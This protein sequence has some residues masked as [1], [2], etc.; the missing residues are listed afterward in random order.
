M[1]TTLKSAAVALA[2]A[3]VTLVLAGAGKPLPT[4]PIRNWLGQIATT[5]EGGHLRGNPKADIKLVEFVSYTCPHCSHFETESDAT[6]QLALIKSGKGSFEIRSYLR[7]PIDVAASLMIECGA[8][9]KVFGNHS[10][11]LRSQSKWLRE[12]SPSEI[13]RWQNPNFVTRMRYIATDLKLYDVMMPR[14][15][16]KVQLDQCLANKALA[17][18]IADQ[19]TD[20]YTRLKVDSTPSFLLNGELV[21]DHDWAGIQARLK[22]LTK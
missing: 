7:N 5:P 15:Y 19:T 6:L 18:R 9:T 8:A 1:K 17:Q 21:P 16:T 12:P 3:S 11:M 14:G 20:A 13:T 22:P 4:A 10:A 2:L